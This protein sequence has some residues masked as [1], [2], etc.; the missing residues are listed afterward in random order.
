[1]PI[2]APLTGKR[3]ND[4]KNLAIREILWVGCLLWSLAAA[5]RQ[6]VPVSQ[7]GV[8]GD[9]VTLNTR[10]LQQAINDLAGQ[11]GGKLCF[12]AGC[13]LTGS[14]QL[15]NGVELY[16][17]QGATLLGSSNPAHYTALQ[18]SQ[19]LE[20]N[21][22]SQ[23]ALLLADGAE[24]IAI[25]GQGTIDG[26]GRALALAVDSLHHAGIRIDP[27]YNYKRMRP[28][29]TARPK[30][31]FF[32]DCRDIRVQGVSLRSS[33]A[34]GLSFDRCRQMV[35]EDLS[36]VNRAYWNNDGI[37]VT[38]CH[39][40]IIRRCDIDSAD[41]GICLKSYHADTC[42]DSIA[43]SDCT[44]RSSAS[45]VKFGTASRGG[46]RNV[47]ISRIRVKDT[48]RSAIAIESVDGGLIEHI[49]VSDVVA[50][51]TGNAL[52]IR[53]G[54][55]SGEAPGQI[56]DV[57]ISRLWCEVPFDRPDLQYDLR[58]PEV[59]FFHNP[60]PSSIT[61]IPGACVEDVTLE[62]IEI[63]CPGRSSKG[64]AYLPLHRLQNVPEKVQDYPEFSMFGELPC[65]AL[66]VRHVRG[67][68]MKRVR[69]MLRDEEFRPA[70]VLD[71]VQGTEMEQV[72]SN[73]EKPWIVE[74]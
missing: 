57:H 23:L 40:V 67:L 16:L 18:K 3:K 36:V 63:V 30:L 47:E 29:E 26:N 37:D 66:Y 50:T 68:Q 19:D 60:F 22:N 20:R 71:D 48:F 5:A 21:D 9:G 25:T 35:L 59:D 41:D 13:Y 53:L 1:M 17:E 70:I 64:M 8:R 2:F 45:A 15:R 61:G 10:Q 62:D 24:Q 56:R 42:N 65:W 34:W 31:F 44:I 74:K 12:P 72:E 69:L 32:V 73:W 28:N 55:R 27:H 38:D 49:R 58:G 54:H 46:F 11:G 14:L 52:F 4:M 43:I 33:A 7:W 39:N 6:E 51:R